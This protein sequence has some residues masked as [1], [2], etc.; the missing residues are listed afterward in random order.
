MTDRRT[1]SHRKGTT[2]PRMTCPTC[3]REV[4]QRDDGTPVVHKG[5]HANGYTRTL[6]NC[7]GSLR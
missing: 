3:G 1:P 4:A 2:M 6:R 5:M 7:T